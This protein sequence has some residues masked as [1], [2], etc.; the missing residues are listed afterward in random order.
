MPKLDLTI[1]EHDDHLIARVAGDYDLQDAIDWFPAV[2]A[3][4]RR[5]GRTKV[6]IDYRGIEGIPA[7]TQK[8]LYALG[9]VDQLAAHAAAGG[10]PL[11]LAYL[12]PARAV[13]SNDP[14]VEIGEQSGVDV[15][16]FADEGEA[17]EWLG[18]AG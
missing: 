5:T 12:G 4:C 8:V 14:G 18:V 6:L 13:F 17:R 9:V 1:D 7:A 15:G 11:K 10:A 16:V 2:V 3:A